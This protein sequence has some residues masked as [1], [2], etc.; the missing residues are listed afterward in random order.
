MFAPAQKIL[1]LPLVSDD[2]AHLGVLEPQPLHRVVQL[3]VHAEVV[4]V[5]LE[6]VAGAQ[7]ALLV[8]VHGE[9]R[10]RAVDGEPPVLVA[11]RGHSELD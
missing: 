3:D 2:R 1:S 11:L 7:A 6:L 10:D 8:D 5:E 9:G 4:G